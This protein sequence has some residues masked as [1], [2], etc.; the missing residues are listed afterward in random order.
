M[1]VKVY[2]SAVYGVEAR[3]IAVE[4]DVNNQGKNYAIVGL[5]DNA[6]KESLQRIE[7]AIKSNR[8]YMPR[9]RLLVNL[10]PAD[11]RKTGTAFDLPIAI[12]TLAATGQ[13][14]E[15]E[16]LASYVIMGELSLDGLVKPIKGVLPIALQ[17][18]NENF[19]GLIVPMANAR[20]AAMVSDLQ[21]YGVNHMNEVVALLN[22][23]SD[24]KPIEADIVKAFQDAQH[25]EEIDFSD[26]KGQQHIKRALEIA[27]AGGHNVI[28]IGPPGAGKTMLAKRLPTIL[29]P[30]TIEEALE[31]TKIHSVAGKITEHTSIVNRRPFRSPHHSISDAALVGGGG[32]PQ[33]GEI[34]LAHHGVLFLDE[35]PEFKRTVLEVMRQPME[36]R[37][38]VI[39]R[40]RIALEFPAS[41]MLIASM[42]PC[43]C[44][45]FNHPEKECTCAPGVVQKYLNKISGPLLD[46]IDLHV[47]VT[48]VPFD[49]LTHRVETESSS[50]IRTRVQQARA[51][52]SE[53]YKNEKEIHANAQMSSKQLKAI[54][55]V[56]AASHEMLKKAME[57]LN[58]SARAYDRILKVSRTIA[59]LE[60]EK[61]ILNAHLAE[62][63]QYRSLDRAS[64]GG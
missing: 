30:L 4:V 8:Y 50:V 55:K 45:Y 47:E 37:K 7:S 1:L 3:T 16:W 27:A 60:G 42:N 53:R 58:L 41:F 54:C 31:T 33:P 18:R 44:G 56:D 25:H 63:I 34:S 9:T 6:V 5:P 59:D 28:L 61:N 14:A 40:A 32:N 20:E 24:I 57:R 62:A 35:L 49:E 2:G 48:P 21:I 10:A 29:P 22:G 64:W 36:E 15:Q 46:R 52:Q 23:N 19:K 39:S 38:V 51:I 11:I 26:V 12:G 17:T 43:P 13:I